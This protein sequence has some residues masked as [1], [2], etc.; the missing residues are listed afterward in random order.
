M[1]IKTKINQDGFHVIEAV[2]ILVVIGVVGLVGWRVIS[3]D[4]DKQSNKNQSA[5]TQGS[6]ANPAST[7]PVERGKALSGGA[8]KG[9][10]SKKLGS[11]PMRTSQMSIVVPYGLLAGGHVTPVDHQ[12]YWGKV[13]MGD[14]DMYDVLASSDGKIVNIG[15]RDH[16]QNADYSKSKTKGD[17]RVVIS[18]SC[19]FFSYF[20]LATSLSSDIQSK[21]PKDWEHGKNPVI[22][23]DIDV[24]QGQVVGKVGGQSLDYAVWDT[25]KF[26]KNFAVREAYDVAEP[27]KVVT[28]HPLDYYTDAVKAQVLPFYARTAEPRDGTID[29]DVDS[30][31]RG[32]WFKEGTYG[33]AGS[34][35]PTGGGNYYKGH[36]AMVHDLY[37]D[38]AQMFSIGDY[39]GQ[40]LQFMVKNPL[41]SFDKLNASDGVVKFELCQP[42]Y[43]DENGRTWNVQAPAKK[44]T[45]KTAANC[46][47]TALVQMVEKRKL[48]VQVFPNKTPSQVSGFT[49]AV[50]Y[51][52]GEDAKNAD[53][54]KNPGKPTST[55][56]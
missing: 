13:Q 48:K 35:Q 19:T 55:A 42:T 27:W 22:N 45:A 12:Y 36:L 29:Q 18:Y 52:R 51:T 43:V 34:A 5:I 8:C 14:P 47:G 1:S 38:S 44:V 9:E 53:I 3:K 23:T 32:G 28:V 31:F 46:P 21:L 56:Y 50:T 54:F 10:G 25:T 30:A 33:Y 37:D 11:L 24:K 6:S 26:L 7:N 39:N 2:I 41:K 40:P 15:Y 16:T 4:K 17:Y 49:A 20:D